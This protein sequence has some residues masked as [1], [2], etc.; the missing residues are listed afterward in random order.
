MTPIARGDL[1]GWEEVQKVLESFTRYT[2][3]KTSS[4]DNLLLFPPV[5]PKSEPSDMFHQPVLGLCPRDMKTTNDRRQA[6][7][8]RF[9]RSY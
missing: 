7:P 8:P 2:F 5:V 9:D 6:I 4:L 3:V 1:P